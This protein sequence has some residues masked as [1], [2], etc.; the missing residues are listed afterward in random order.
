MPGAT[1][2][3]A[4]SGLPGAPSFRG[5]TTSSGAPRA[6]ATG[7]ATATPPRG[8]ASTVAGSTIVVARASASAA[9]ASSRS[10]NTP[11]IIAPALPGASARD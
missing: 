5:I 3:I 9:P 4:S 2:P 11:S 6:R 1:A 7:T 8:I 10:R